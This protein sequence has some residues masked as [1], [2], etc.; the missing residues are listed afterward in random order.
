MVFFKRYK[1]NGMLLF[2]NIWLWAILFITGC[3]TVKTP[4]WSENEVSRMSEV[5]QNKTVPIV[6]IK[7]D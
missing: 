6:L 1:I 2:W 5:G 3:S 4:P 7:V